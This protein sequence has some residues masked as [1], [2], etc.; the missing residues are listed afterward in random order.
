MEL[1]QFCFNMLFDMDPLR[2]CLAFGPLVVY[3]S[4]LGAI[5]LTRR[6]FL[7]S[8]GRDLAALTLAIGGLAL[9]GPI[10]LFLP[11]VVRVHFG[12]YVWVMVF[13]LY[14]LLATMVILMLRPRL[15][16]YNMTLDK[17]RPILADVVERLDGDARWAGDSL[18]LPH[19]GVQLHLDCFASMKN[20]SLKSIGGQQN[21]QGWKKLENA[22]SSAISTEKFSRNW[23][24]LTLFLAG[25]AFAV[26]VLLAILHNPDS[27]SKT[28]SDLAAFFLQWFR[29]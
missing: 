6:P 24:G 15:V 11:E 10:D 27:L 3:L 5:N 20:V 18:V 7:V 2:L 13:S 9:V 4:L 17:L 8:G 26:L 28:L 22:L 29:R 19:L 25:S 16:I 21:F 14:A 1:M 12:V 23:Q